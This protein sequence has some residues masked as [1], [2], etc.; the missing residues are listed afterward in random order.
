MAQR[1]CQTGKGEDMSVYVRQD[2]IIVKKETK[3][4][5]D[6]QLEGSK[7]AFLS[8]SMEINCFTKEVIIWLGI[9]SRIVCS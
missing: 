8:I 5:T 3:D 9:E 2:S 6:A 7:C 4:D 1:G